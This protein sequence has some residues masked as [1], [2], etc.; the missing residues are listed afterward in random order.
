MSNESVKSF[1]CVIVGGGM[2]GGAT[3]LA[4]SDLGLSV[5]I[6]EAHTPKSFDREQDFDLRVSAISVASEQLLEQLQAWQQISEWRTCPY[7]RLGVFEDDIAYAEFNS[8]EIGQSHLGHIIENRLIQLS[9]WQQIETRAN[10]HLY[11]PQTLVG[12]EQTAESI[13]VELNNENIT[14]KLLIGADGANSKVRQLANIGTTGWDYKQSAMLINVETQLP[15]QDITWQ[16]FING[17][18][19]AFLPMPGN[20][21]SLVWYD[22]RDEINRLVKL[23]NEQLQDEIAAHF[24]VKLGSIVVKDKGAFPL[25]RR[26]A[27]QYVE[28]RVVLLGDSAHTINPLAGQG[29]NLGFKDVAALQSVIAK[30]IGDGENFD[31]AKVLQRYQQK[32]KPDNLVM[33]G[34]MD[35]IYATFNNPSTPIKLLRNIGMFAAHRVPL[36]KQKALKYACGL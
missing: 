3:A 4:L 2:V 19:V 7:K 11:C 35:A 22:S 31:D 24:P 32:R 12:F 14:S 29:V 8:D 25:T 30:A 23:T 10:I 20:N 18:P 6:V 1:D 5:A 34:A 26:H 15:Q 21:G 17:A 13:T 16:Q 9:I 27:N 33:Q 28:N 36:L